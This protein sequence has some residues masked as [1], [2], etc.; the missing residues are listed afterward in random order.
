MLRKHCFYLLDGRQVLLLK[1]LVSHSSCSSPSDIDVVVGLRGPIAPRELCNGL[2][3]PIV[4]FDQIYSFNRLGERLTRLSAASSSERRSG[5]GFFAAMFLS[6]S[7]LHICH[8]SFGHRL[9]FFL[10]CACEL[11][12]LVHG[13]LYSELSQALS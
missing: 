1:D 2:M 5:R 7:V 9:E 11:N 12:N 8:E 3:V 4:A 10:A 6:P 13:W